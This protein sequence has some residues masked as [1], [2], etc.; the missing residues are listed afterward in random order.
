MESGDSSSSN[1]QKPSE[2]SGEPVEIRRFAALLRPP[3]EFNMDV[4]NKSLAWKKWIKQFRFFSTASG[5]DGEPENV[6]VAT[7]MTCLGEGVLDIFDAFEFEAGQENKLEV[8]IEKFGEIFKLEAG[9][10]TQERQIFYAMTQ[11]SRNFNDFLSE[12]QI[13]AKKCNFGDSQSSMI[14]DQIIRGVKESSTKE[15]LHRKKDLDMKS[16][17]E[18][19]RTQERV[20]AL[21]KDSTQ[22]INVVKRF[23]KGSKQ[24]NSDECEKCGLVHG[25]K[26]PAYGQTCYE[27]NGRNHYARCCSKRKSKSRKEANTIELEDEEDD[28]SLVNLRLDS[29]KHQGGDWFEDVALDGKK[30]T[31][32]LDSGAQCNVVSRTTAIK[33]GFEKVKKSRAKNIVSFNNVKSPILGEFAAKIKTRRG[34][35]ALVKFRVI[36]EEI[37]PVLGRQSCVRLN[38]IQRVVQRPTV[39]H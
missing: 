37:N 8:V 13:Q 19:C 17:I 3:R 16:A 1:G 12:L 23:D 25:A 10:E 18:I 14:R 4:E 31:V 15:K 11:G 32:K 34:T 30:V 33:L 28:I 9:N 26:C 35:T 36:D 6:Q 7:L 5:L 39:R 22:E 27:C 38:L 24:R 29:I 2:D 21:M 20:K